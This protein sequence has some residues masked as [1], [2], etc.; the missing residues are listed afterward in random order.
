MN[1]AYYPKGTDLSFVSISHEEERALF[2]KAKAGD[3]AAKEQLIRSHLLLVA[4]LARKLCK[5]RLPEDQI[6]S[7]ANFALMKAYENFRPEFPNRFS[8]F[9]QLHVRGEI[10]RLWLEQNVV[11]K[12][13]FS[14]GEPITSVP[15]SEESAE[16][17]GYEDKAHKEFLI[18]LSEE[19]KS[20]L[21][22][23]ELEIVN[24]LFCELPMNQSEVARKLKLSRERIRQVYN[25][26][27]IKLQKELR[28]LMNLH[29]IN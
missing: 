3:E 18:K 13:D 10:A 26:A 5:G 6:V 14:D 7:A 9:L 8:G 27:L 12:T 23:R 1:D 22:P 29:G 19:A 24:L 4:N 11:H 25:G 17:T 20:V 21:D 2:K 28:R 15:L 16:E